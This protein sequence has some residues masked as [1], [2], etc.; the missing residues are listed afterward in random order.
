MTNT[1][2]E[3]KAIIQKITALERAEIRYKE[4]QEMYQNMIR[5]LEGLEKV[6]QKE[7]DDIKKLEKLGLSSLFHKVLGNKDEQLEIERQEYLTVNLKYK[8]LNNNIDAAEFELKLLENKFKELPDAKKKLNKLLQVREKEILTLRSPRSTKLLEV[9]QQEDKEVRWHTEIIEAIHI[10]E[11]VVS[12]LDRIISHLLK[13]QQWGKVDL[14]SK[15]GYPDYMKHS[16]IDRATN[17]I[18]QTKPLL[19]IFKKE[20]ED[21]GMGHHLILNLKSFSMFTDVFFDNLISDW[22]IQNKIKN[23]LSSINATRDKSTQII[24]G[25]EVKKSK[26]EQEIEKLFKL[27]N[28]IL[29]K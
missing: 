12:A 18:Y 3:I 5:Q 13:A 9:I 22:I 26:S 21:I 20:L 15:G 14:F 11:K 6:M 24:N 4:T 10:G 2:D 8:E 25:L 19:L 7:L 16:A 28:E 1:A 23:A 17:E 29:S 27:K